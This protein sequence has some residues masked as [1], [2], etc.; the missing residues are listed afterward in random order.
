MTAHPYLDTAGPI[1]IAHRGGAREA[2]ENTREAFEY[3]VSLGYTYVETDCHLTADGVVVA[4][5]DPDLDRVSNTTGAINQWNWDDLATVSI[6]GG[7]TMTS[8]GE[9]LTD[10]P[11]TRFNIDVKSDEVALPLLEVIDENRAY[12]RVCIGSFSDER[13]ATIRAAR[14]GK[15]CT[16]FGP[17][18]VLRCVVGSFGVPIEPRAGDALQ[19]PPTFRGAP[20]LTERLVSYAHAQGLF[21]HVWTI[22]DEDE[23]HR[24]LDLGVDGIMT[25]RPSMLKEVFTARGLEL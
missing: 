12:D 5:H 4:F 1:A 22:D 16:S 19:I 10:F 2:P 21:V 24:L 17:R 15:V 20:L 11:E 7:G 25:D 9:L 8:V 18:G 14:T 23:M 3:A 6:N 13:L